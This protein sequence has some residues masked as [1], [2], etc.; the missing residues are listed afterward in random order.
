LV[1]HG[2]ALLSEVYQGRESL[3]I[4]VT[5]SMELM[6]TVVREITYPP[7]ATSVRSK[8]CQ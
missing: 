4:N 5:M 7:V 6:V 2:R 3:E 8:R 1:I